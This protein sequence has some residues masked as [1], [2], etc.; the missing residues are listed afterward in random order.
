MRNRAPSLL[1]GLALLASAAFAQTSQPA[2]APA[3]QAQENT[4]AADRDADAPSYARHYTP[5]EVSTYELRVRDPDLGTELIGV[6]EHRVFVRGGVPTEKIRWIRLTESQVGEINE[7]ALEVPAYEMSLHPRGDLTLIDVKGDPVMLEMVTDLYAFYFAVSPAAGIANLRRAGDGYVRPELVSNDWA[8]GNQFLVGQSRTQ[9]RL[10]LASV[11]P[12]EVVYE[13]NL[14]PPAVAA[15][16]MQ[17]PWMEAP[18]CGDT[19]NNLQFVRRQD[20]GFLAAWGCEKTQITSRVDPATGKLLAAFMN[21]EMT[22]SLKLCTDQALQNCEDRPQVTRHRQIE[23]RLR[24]AP[25][26]QLSSDRIRVN[27][28]NGLEYVWIP[29]GSFEMGCVPSDEDCYPEEKPAHAVTLTHGFWMSRTEVPVYAYE[30]FREA[31]GG[32]MPEE[33]GSGAMHDYNDGWAKKNHPMVKVTWNEAAAF[34]GWSG[35]R[36]PTEAEW[37]YAARG[38]VDG[39]KYPWGNDRSHDQAN[40]WR[41]GGQDHWKHTAP[42]G[43]FPPN[44]F[45]LHDM[46]GNVYEWVGD[47][48][49]EDYY[50][51][52]PAADPKGPPKGRLRVARGGAGFLNP[53]V[54]RISTRLRS[55]PD[56]RNITVGLR[57]AADEKP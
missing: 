8:D 50:G 41:T 28:K 52:S 20:D 39:L 46:A 40:Y 42:I 5:G 21:N 29:S 12:K 15:L 1:S 35:G 23:L 31:T 57:C 2:T 38:G 3:P 56:T 22:W 24:P 43:S 14:L 26:E 37:E 36:L 49:S 19:P 33:P 4:A 55:A 9:V 51:A 48:F 34:C 45:G 54:L 47:W 7:M 32:A 18:V 17:R 11:A 44:T 53:A 30:R 25:A 6:S 13:S 16:E 27:P 10:G